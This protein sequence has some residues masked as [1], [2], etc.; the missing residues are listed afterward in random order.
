MPGAIIIEDLYEVYLHTALED[1]SSYCLTIAKESSALHTILLLIN[2]N[3][4]ILQL[5]V[6]QYTI[7]YIDNIPIRG[8]TSTYQATDGTF[9]TIPE[10]SGIRHFIWEHFQ[11]LNCIVQQMKYCGG[12]FSSK[13]LLLCVREITIVGH[14][15]T[16]ESH[17][18]DP[19]R[20]DKIINWGPCKDLSEV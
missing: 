1:R 18:P 7:P 9:K 19:S 17:V 4:Y 20:V 15:C 6:P 14:V 2:H 8:P 11:N 13:K 16:P 5:E 10:N 12:M 3:Q